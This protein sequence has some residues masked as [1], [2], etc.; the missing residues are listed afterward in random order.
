MFS[1]LLLIPWRN[2]DGWLPHQGGCGESSRCC[3]GGTIFA[4]GAFQPL[5]SGCSSI[6]RSRG[7]YSF[8]KERDS[9]CGRAVTRLSCTLKALPRDVHF[10]SWIC[11]WVLINVISARFSKNECCLLF[12]FVAPFTGSL[13]C[14]G[15]LFSF[16][17]AC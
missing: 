17:D 5:D 13:L 9:C 4:R 15:Q 12:N 16:R 2:P 8:P 11:A 10:H 6:P 1:L 3:P 7:G 14:A